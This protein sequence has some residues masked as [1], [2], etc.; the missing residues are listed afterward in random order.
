MVL[1]YSSEEIIEILKKLSKNS[2]FPDTLEQEITHYMKYAGQ[3]K[4]SLFGSDYY[5]FVSESI[6]GLI[7]ED[8]EKI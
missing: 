1:H 2:I 5:F 7:C 3:V 8:V 6:Y 4:F